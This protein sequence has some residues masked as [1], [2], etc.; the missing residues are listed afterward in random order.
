MVYQ[1]SRRRVV[2]LNL[3]AWLMLELAEPAQSLGTLT[4]SYVRHLGE[5]A[6]DPFATAFAHKALGDLMAQ[7]LIRL[8]A[9][10]HLERE[11]TGGLRHDT[12]RATE[13]FDRSA[14]T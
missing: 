8:R 14:G 11:T 13:T 5:H 6:G 4:D 10:A 3:S 1:R 12:R 2:H 7:G 9:D